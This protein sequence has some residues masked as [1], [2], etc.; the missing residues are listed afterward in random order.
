MLRTP[1]P[2]NG[3][4][5]GRAPII[6]YKCSLD[7]DALNGLCFACGGYH[8]GIVL[9]P[10]WA[11]TIDGQGSRGFASSIRAPAPIP[12]WMAVVLSPNTHRR[13]YPYQ[14]FGKP[15]KPEQQCTRIAAST[16]P[17]C[18][19]VARCGQS[20]LVLGFTGTT[21][22]ITV[23]PRECASRP[24]AAASPSILGIRD[25]GQVGGNRLSPSRQS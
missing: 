4:R 9:H 20:A 24:N 15:F 5:S 23:M 12:R 13:S 8:A 3:H 19:S 18:R 10:A 6:K 22:T 25:V 11:A 16:R 14:L 1:S 2:P 7:G 21:L 17:P